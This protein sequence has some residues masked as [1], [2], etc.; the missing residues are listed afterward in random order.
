MSLLNLVTLSREKSISEG[1]MGEDKPA[2]F[3]ELF[4]TVLLFIMKSNKAVKSGPY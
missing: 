3:S 2:I 1:M 4:S